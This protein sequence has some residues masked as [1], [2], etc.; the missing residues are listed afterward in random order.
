MSKDVRDLGQQ[1]VAAA[2]DAVRITDDAAAQ[3][4]RLGDLLDSV[5]ATQA[6][7][8]GVRMRLVHEAQVAGADVVIDKVRASTRTTTQRA[9]ADLR[10]AH[11]L[12]E[13][14]PLIHQAVC[15]GTI[16]LAQAEGMVTG[17][18]KLPVR[19]TRHDLERCQTTLL[20]E[21]EFLGPQELRVL[22]ARMLEVIHPDAAD[23]ADAV[24]LAR[25]ERLAKA[26]RSLRIKP[27]HHGSVRI[28]GQLPVAD[29]AVL[30]AQ[31]DALLP[32]VTAYA[33]ED[34]TP[35][36]DARQA[37]A[38]VLLTQVAAN[39]GDLPGHGLARPHVHVTL[40]WESL[41]DGLGRVGLLDRGDHEQLTPA[42]ARRLAC[43]AHLIPIVLGGQSQPLDVGRSHRLV[44]TWLRTALTQRDQGCAF[45]HCAAPAAACE[46]HHIRPWWAGGQTSLTNTVL[47]CPHHHRLVE[48][49]PN[50][51]EESQW[52]AH[53]EPATGLPTFLPPRHIDPGRRPRQHR[54][55][56][57]AMLKLI[58]DEAEPASP[59]GVTGSA[60]VS[61][62]C[63][64]SALPPP[65]D[66]KDDPWHPAY[67]PP[68]RS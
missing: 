11:D 62:P 1:L 38:L 65:L 34:F 30:Q 31:S 44:P 9:S 66:P 19:L 48:P 50:Q 14:Y 68:P 55:F 40:Q 61:Q 53:I 23:E 4:A 59:V 57:L 32:P 10:L 20:A 24:R 58:P 6:Q 27:D 26:G 49:V 63:S 18:K 2:W 54:R 7:L 46:A 33:H 21:A 42:E 35:S 39:A 67:E 45:P 12:G 64:V 15:R 37:D 56:R 22:A 43:D 28:T 13:D 8:A 51:S 41:R 60:A 25:E 5:E 36:R 29:G 16:S 47:L 52:R 17:L 3:A